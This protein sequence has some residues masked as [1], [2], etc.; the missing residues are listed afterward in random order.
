[1][2]LI[3][4]WAILIGVLELFVARTSS[5]TAKDRA[6][7]ILGATTAIVVGVAMMIWVFAGAVVASAIVGVAA[8]ARGVSLMISAFTREPIGWKNRAT[9]SGELP[10]HRE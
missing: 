6:L 8:A 7:L 9:V 2:E 4:L 5:G 1:V 10:E 3:G